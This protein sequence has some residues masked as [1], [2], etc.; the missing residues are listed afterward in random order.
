VK[1]GTAMC[2][3]L[4][5]V[6][7]EEVKEFIPRI[8]KERIKGE[9]KTVKRIC[10]S[11][12]IEK[13]INAVPNGGYALRGMFRYKTKITPIIHAYFCFKQ[14]NPNVRFVSPE[15]VYKKYHVLDAESLC[16]WWALDTPKMEHRIV[17]VDNAELIDYTDQF[18]NHGV[19]IRGLE[20]DLI[21]ELPKSAP[22]TWI[23]GTQIEKYGVRTIFACAGKMS[24]DKK[25]LMP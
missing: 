17:K 6:S 10:F 18:G 15:T 14:E 2:N 23:H 25:W 20:Y 11:D 24:E 1:K 7:F 5:H 8:P 19:C 12:S 3:I 13:A 21:K 16:E 4:I 22:E 9:N